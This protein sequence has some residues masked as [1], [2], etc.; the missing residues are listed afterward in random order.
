LISFPPYHPFLFFTL[1][2]LNTV[3]LPHSFYYWHIGLLTFPCTHQAYIQ[4]VFLCV[5]AT[6]APL[7]HS[8]QMSPTLGKTVSV[9]SIK[10]NRNY[11]LPLTS[12]SSLFYFFL[13]I[14]NFHI[15][16]CVII[17]FVFQLKNKLDKCLNLTLFNCFFCRT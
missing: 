10:K 14:F 17:C 1:F 12:N 4:L 7:P 5:L 8:G 11:F 2:Y 6:L 16:Y 15:K 9:H 13:K 3:L